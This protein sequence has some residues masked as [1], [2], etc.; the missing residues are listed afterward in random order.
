MYTNKSLTF[1]ADNVGDGAG[2]AQ[3]VRVLRSDEEAIGRV[4]YEALHCVRVLC[5]RI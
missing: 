4:G 5:Y 3:P 2:N 1:S